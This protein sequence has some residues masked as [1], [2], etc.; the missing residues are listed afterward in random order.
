M[1]HLSF[2][3][4]DDFIKQFNFDKNTADLACLTITDIFNRYCPT[5]N[6]Y[7]KEIY[8]L[9]YTMGPK[10]Y[11]R[12]YVFEIDSKDVN[13]QAVRGVL[14]INTNV[15]SDSEQHGEHSF[16][17]REIL[18]KVKVGSM[19]KL[20]DNDFVIN[21]KSLV[22]QVFQS[23]EAIE[24]KIAQS[25]CY[26]AWTHSAGPDNAFFSKE[27]LEKAGEDFWKNMNVGD[28]FTVMPGGA[29]LKL[30]VSAEQILVTC[31][32][33]PSGDSGSNFEHMRKSLNRMTEEARSETW[34]Q[35]S[36][37]MKAY[38][39][40]HVPAPAILPTLATGRAFPLIPDF[41]TPVSTRFPADMLLN[42]GLPLLELLKFMPTDLFPK[43]N[44]HNHMVMHLLKLAGISDK[45]KPFGNFNIKKVTRKQ[46]TN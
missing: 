39:I 4:I 32:N 9:S 21:K 15:D 2:K 3:N 5:L 31:G 34:K 11:S 7:I 27:M 20:D 33:P 12:T 24:K 41:D 26:N 6:W 17:F 19:Q 23:A 38:G 1:T 43:T 14:I 16:S 28:V 35:F 37:S 40:K 29:L 36:K 44:I 18:L 45:K 10:Q 22:N 30:P 46:P 42:G 13:W 25:D 8:R